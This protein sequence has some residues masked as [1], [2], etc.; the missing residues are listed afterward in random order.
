MR[1]SRHRTEGAA[2]LQECGQRRSLLENRRPLV[3]GGQVV[4]T[5]A[6]EEAVQERKVGSP[7]LHRPRLDSVPLPLHGHRTVSASGQRRARTAHQGQQ[8]RT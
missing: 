7:A 5:P 2:C 8:E 1:T 4:A 6:G 3:D